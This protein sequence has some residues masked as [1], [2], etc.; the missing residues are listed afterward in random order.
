MGRLAIVHITHTRVRFWSLRSALQEFAE[1]HNR[2]ALQEFAEKHN[3]STR[4]R[5][6]S[7]ACARRS[8]LEEFA[9]KHQAV[10]WDL[11]AITKACNPDISIQVLTATRLRSFALALSRSPFCLPPFLSRS[12]ALARALRWNRT[13]VG[14]MFAYI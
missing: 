4:A 1:K 3:D 8:P 12:R 11:R 14:R 5:T 6:H 7:H 9:K 10:S 2:S 13:R